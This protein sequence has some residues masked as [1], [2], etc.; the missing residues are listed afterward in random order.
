MN[1]PLLVFAISLVVLSLSAWIGTSFRKRRSL[2]EDEREDF[3]VVLAATLT[4]LGLII[5]FSFSM[6]ISRYDQR[7]NYEEAE[8]N[9][10]GTEYVRTDLL[11]SP[12]AAKVNALLRKYL[13]QR[14]LFYRTRDQHEL[15]QINDY[16]ARLQTEL[17]SAVRI[18]AS[19]QP[20]P[21]IALAVAGMNDVLN[22][23]GYTQA[24]WWNRIPVGAW[25]LMAAIAIC[26]NLLIGYGA[27]RPKQE[28]ILFLVLPLVVS[29]SFFL[30]ADIDSPRGGVIRVAPQNLMSLSQ[31]L[32]GH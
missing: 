29:I 28:T 13:E 10:I 19:A 16:T 32:P 17:W 2:E 30:I 8:A 31:S 4:L 26:C 25:V 9:A 6:A 21:V 14:I 12:D 3:G 20:T 7:K 18:P 27:R 24:A 5:G 23:Q 1:F 22:S 15:L 11:P